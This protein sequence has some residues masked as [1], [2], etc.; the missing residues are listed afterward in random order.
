MTVMKNEGSRVCLQVVV[1]TGG[2]GQWSAGGDSEWSAGSWLQVGTVSGQQGRGRRWGW[3][4]VSRVVVAGG[5]APSRKRA[6]LSAQLLTA[7]LQSVVSVML[8]EVGRKS[9]EGRNHH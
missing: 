7:S 5:T 1:V 9:S 6:L 3:P 4:A 2:D 8:P